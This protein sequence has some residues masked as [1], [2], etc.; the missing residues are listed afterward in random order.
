MKHTSKRTP[1]NWLN[2][3]TTER[4]V[5]EMDTKHMIGNTSIESDLET[6]VTIIQPGSSSQDT[7]NLHTVQKSLP[8]CQEQVDSMSLALEQAGLDDFV[9]ANKLNT[10]MESAYTSTPEGD[11]IPDFKTMLDAIKVYL[12]MK[13]GTPDTQINIANIFGGK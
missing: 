13:K 12:K 5:K 9:V 2:Q 8:T 6:G 1:I 4:K 3:E 10:I 7:N 11:I